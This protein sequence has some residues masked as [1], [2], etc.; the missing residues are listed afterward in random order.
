MQCIVCLLNIL[1]FSD[2]IIIFISFGK[3]TT[4]LR[5]YVSIFET[6]VN[7]HPMNINERHIETFPAFLVWLR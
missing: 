6:G 3:G 1:V 5:E 7:Q 4:P 2:K